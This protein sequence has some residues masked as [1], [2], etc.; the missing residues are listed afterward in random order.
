MTYKIFFFSDLFGI[1]TFDDQNNR[2]LSEYF[3]SSDD[4]TI[5]K[6]LNICRSKNVPYSGLEWSYECH[7]GN[8]PESGFE[9]AWLDKCNDKC[10]GDSSQTCGG[11]EALNVWNTPPKNLF[12]YC[13]HDYPS[14]KRV[15]NEFSVTG[16]EDM[17]IELCRNFCEGTN[18][19][20]I[21]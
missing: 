14:N 9:W 16:R 17:T 8:A 12:G 7:C 3:E 5:E 19:F 10:A 1:C 15:L 20:I 4:M 6:C 21:A 11:S 2:I 13:V 18:R